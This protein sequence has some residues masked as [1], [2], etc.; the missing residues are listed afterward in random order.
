MNTT[1]TKE[2]TKKNRFAN[3]VVTHTYLQ[4]DFWQFPSPTF[5][6][7]AENLKSHI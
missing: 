3:R 1:F 2:Q 4:S 5:P 6:I 7:F